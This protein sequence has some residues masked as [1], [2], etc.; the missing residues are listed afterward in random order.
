[1]KLAFS[2]SLEL[3]SPLR[4]IGCLFVPVLDVLGFCSEKIIPSMMILFYRSDGEI[5]AFPSTTCGL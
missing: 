5:S 2:F 4:T 1:M 3:A